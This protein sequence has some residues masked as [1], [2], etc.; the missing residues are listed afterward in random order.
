M[1]FAGN[2]DYERVRYFRERTF[3]GRKGRLRFG[4]VVDT[5]QAQYES[6]GEEWHTDWAARYSHTFGDWDV[7]LHYFMGT[8]RDPSFTLGTGDGGGPVNNLCVPSL[9]APAY[10]PADRH[11]VSVSSVGV[12]EFPQAVISDHGSHAMSD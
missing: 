3:P 6:A 2:V 8:G 1:R 11:L 9:V 12:A 5:D 4:F 7:G 10:A